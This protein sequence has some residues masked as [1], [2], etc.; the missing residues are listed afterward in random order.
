MSGVILGSLPVGERVGIAFSGGLDTCCALAWMREKG[1]IPYA[2]TADLGQY[3]EPDI[4]AVPDEGEAVRRGGGGA[5][6]L[7]RRARAPGARGAAVRRVPH[8]HRRPHVLQHDPARPR[9]HRD[10]A[11]ARDGTS[12]ASRSGATAR[13][14]R[15]T[16][17]SASTATAC[18]RTRRSGSTSRG[19]TA[20]SSP[21]SAA[22]RRCASGSS[23]AASRT[24]TSVEKAYSTDANMLGATHEAKDLELLATSMKIVEPIMGVRFW[25]PGRRDRARG[26]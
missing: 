6:R 23:S 26:R 5:R 24:S 9:R 1:A 19:S 10:D 3:D 22:A 11:R 14:T 20:R 18:S 4:G 2:F 12:T 16:T 8:P 25:D 13:R 21:S 17:S 15:A 7:P